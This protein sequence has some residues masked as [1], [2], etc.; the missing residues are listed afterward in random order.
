MNILLIGQNGK[1]GSVVRNKLESDGHNVITLPRG[2]FSAVDYS[3]AFKYEPLGLLDDNGAIINCAGFTNIDAAEKPE[4]YWNTYVANDAIPCHLANLSLEKNIPII[5]I[6]TDYVYKDNGLT[7][8]HKED[9]ALYTL[10]RYAHSKLRGEKQITDRV[11]SH[12]ILRTSWL[13]GD[14]NK[15]SWIDYFNESEVPPYTNNQFGSPTY[16]PDI[17]D[18]V[19]FI[20]ENNPEYGIYNFTNSLNQK[21]TITKYDIMS[22]IR[23]KMNLGTLQLYS[24]NQST[25]DENLRPKNSSLNTEKWSQNCYQPPDL[26]TSISKY[27]KEGYNETI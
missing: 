14:G 17:A 6:S 18:A 19:S 16:I 21:D 7:I 3:Y 23:Y 13:F 10:S 11:S 2:F 24:S 8:F 12:Y 20:I 26:L 25:Y 5:H 9:D 22:Y 4:N 15:K 1:L 27:F